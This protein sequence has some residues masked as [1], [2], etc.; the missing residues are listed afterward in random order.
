MVEFY[1]HRNVE[2][3]W[4]STIALIAI[5]ANLPGVDGRS[6]IETCRVAVSMISALPSVSLRGLSRW[7]LSAPVPPSGQPDY[8][9]AVAAVRVGSAYLADPALLLRRLMDVE[10]ACGRQRSVANAARTLDLDMIAIG[11]MVRLSPDP[12]LPHPRAHERAFVLMPLLDVAPNWVHPVLHRP[13]RDLLAGLPPQP[14][15]PLE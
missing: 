13:A 11:D 4:E 15:H 1:G 10:T 5:G 3:A 6:P 12:I 9:N 14:I 7:F 2:W 8:V